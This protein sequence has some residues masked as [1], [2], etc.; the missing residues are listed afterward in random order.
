MC[1]EGDLYPFFFFP[2]HQGFIYGC[3]V[4][5]SRSHLVFFPPRWVTC[6]VPQRAAQAVGVPQP[7]GLVNELWHLKPWKTRRAG[8]RDRCP[9]SHRSDCLGG[10][11]G[12]PMTSLEGSP[13][14]R[15]PP[16]FPPGALRR[17]LRRTTGGLC[18]LVSPL[19]VQ[20]PMP[21]QPKVLPGGDL[22]PDLWDHLCVG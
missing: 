1:H 9:A 10:F 15:A 3:E 4:A 7:P 13:D 19:C 17:G 22:H 5:L 14:R 18:P 6:L 2:L 11:A 16:R 12:S 21:H 20:T 8:G